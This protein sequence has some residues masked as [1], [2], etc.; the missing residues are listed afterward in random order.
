MVRLSTSDKPEQVRNQNHCKSWKKHDA[1]NR[2][3]HNVDK[4]YFLVFENRLN[5]GFDQFQLYNI[6]TSLQNYLKRK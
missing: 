4:N 6:V 2:N 5:H 1:T 3:F